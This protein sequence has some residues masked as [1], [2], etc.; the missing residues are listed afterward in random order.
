MLRPYATV[1]VA[2]TLL[3]PI[4]FGVGQAADVGTLNVEGGIAELTLSPRVNP[5]EVV[6]RTRTGR[7]LRIVMAGGTVS[8]LPTN[9]V[10]HTPPPGGDMLPDGVVTQGQ[11]NIRRAWLTGPTDRYGHS[12]LGDAIEASGVAAELSGGRVTRFELGADAV[13]EDR[14]TRFADMNGDGKDEILVVKSYLKRGGALTALTIAGG[15][16]IVAG[17]APPIGRANR[18]LNPIGAADFDGDGKMEAAVVITP[19]IGGSLTLYRLQAGRLVKAYAAD[20]FSNH[21][22][23][24]RELGLSAIL[25]ANGDR[26]PDIAVPDAR[27]HAIRVVTFAQGRFAELEHLHVPGKL[28][29]AL[30]A[31][32]IDGDG[33]KELFY[34]AGADRL[35]V[36]KF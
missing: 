35:V 31:L 29:T 14:L 13:F 22:I 33:R 26:V 1:A 4:T 23:G 2:A 5:M 25:D 18:W 21:A 9:P 34:G 8:L 32:D 19:H 36:V 20:G 16:L 11:N 27:R 7:H 17:E 3:L 28:A 15:K 10:T 24:S 6:V 12:V 30:V